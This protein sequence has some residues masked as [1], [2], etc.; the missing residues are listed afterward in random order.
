L[1]LSAT[2]TASADPTVPAPLTI[3]IVSDVVC[4]WCY[5]GKR[6]LEAALALPEAAD[7]PP[8]QIRWHP[9][10]LNP[11]LPEAGMPRKQYLEE[12]FGGPARAAEIYARVHAAGVAV[13]LDLNFKANTLAAHALIAFAQQDSRN[14]PDNKV[15]NLVKELLLKAYFVEGR[16]I[17]SLDVLAEVAAEAGL[18]ADAAR[19]YLG[20]AANR[21][22]IAQAD[23]QARQMGVTGVPFFIFNQKVAVS[24]AQDPQTL[25]AA[26][27]QAV[28]ALKKP[29]PA[30]PEE[31]SFTNASDRAR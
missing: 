15:G 8:V 23:A 2:A 18:D 26:M 4:P 24:G 22:E 6:K 27:Q 17:G 29:L 21:A 25:L 28:A 12:K 31:A 9:F 11:D 20:N 19:A 16:F 3:D 5:I 10:Q 30:Q 14:G 1:T 7:L 13:G